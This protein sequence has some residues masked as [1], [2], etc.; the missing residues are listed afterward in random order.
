[1]GNLITMWEQ[2]S[3]P[4]FLLKVTEDLEKLIPCPEARRYTSRASKIARVLF[5]EA[6]QNI[7]VSSTKNTPELMA[8]KIP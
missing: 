8:N 2:R 4:V 5:G 1:M 3:S 6:R 7:N